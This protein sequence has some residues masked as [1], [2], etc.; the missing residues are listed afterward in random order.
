[1]AAINPDAVIERAKQKFGSLHVQWDEQAVDHSDWDAIDAVIA[2]TEEASKRACERC[3]GPSHIS[4]GPS[5]H[6][7]STFCDSCRDGRAGR[8]Q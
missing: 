5:V 7:L 8:R 4:G 3:G 6:S 1:M 2:L